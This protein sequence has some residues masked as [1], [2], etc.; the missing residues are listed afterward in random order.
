MHIKLSEEDKE[1]IIKD[2]SAWEKK[3][4][5]AAYEYYNGNAF[6]ILNDSSCICYDCFKK[7]VENDDIDINDVD[8]IAFYIEG[9]ILQCESCNKFIHPNYY[10]CG[11]CLNAIEDRINDCCK[12]TYDCLIANDYD[13]F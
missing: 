3:T 1:L 13:G 11:Q 6:I 5:I 8:C 7:D 10:I 12:E 9:D 2:F 4:D